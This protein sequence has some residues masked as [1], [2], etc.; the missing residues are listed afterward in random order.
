MIKNKEEAIKEDVMI[1]KETKENVVKT[2]KIL[3]AMLKVEEV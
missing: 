3:K 1:K 2:E